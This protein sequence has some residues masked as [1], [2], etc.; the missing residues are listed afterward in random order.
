MG[1][2]TRDG[3]GGT[4]SFGKE[5]RQ[6]HSRIERSLSLSW[7][8][9]TAPES[10]LSEMFVFDHTLRLRDSTPAP[11]REAINQQIAALRMQ[12]WAETAVCLLSQDRTLP[13]GTAY[14]YVLVLRAYPKKCN[15]FACGVIAVR[16]AGFFG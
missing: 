14:L 2:G 13:D 5:R 16:A 11:A 8:D 1:G 12:S 9:R 10:A 3:V 15:L 6:P 7:F 4:P